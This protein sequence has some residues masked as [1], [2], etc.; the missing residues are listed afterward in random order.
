MHISTIVEEPYLHNILD[1]YSGQGEVSGQLH[2][3]DKGLSIWLM[4][5]IKCLVRLDA[6]LFG[7]LD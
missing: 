4:D 5:E 2:E 7:E 1:I 6:L 3:E